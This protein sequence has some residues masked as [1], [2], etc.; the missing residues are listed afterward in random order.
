M[1]K[2]LFALFL[3]FGFFTIQCKIVDFGERGT[4]IFVNIERFYE[5]QESSSSYAKMDFVD[6]QA[7][8]DNAGVDPNDVRRVTL[9]NVQIIIESNSTGDATEADGE[10]WFRLQSPGQPDYKLASF[11]MT[12][13]N[14]ILNVPIDPFAVGATHLTLETTGVTKLKEFLL[15]NPAPTIV[16][17][18]RGNVNTP[19]IDFDARLIVDLIVEVKIT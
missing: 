18:F 2:K 11:P 16:F 8:Y 15:F 14:S 7:E 3:I 10:I 12:N 19:P 4:N 9:S 6:I 17:Y 5:A 1:F 13:L